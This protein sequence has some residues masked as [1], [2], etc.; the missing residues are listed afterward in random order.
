MYPPSTVAL[1]QPRLREIANRLSQMNGRGHELAERLNDLRGRVGMPM[2]TPT[3]PEPGKG[4]P[5]RA[6]EPDALTLL[7]MACDNYAAVL[8]R[9][10]AQADA[11][12]GLA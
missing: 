8:R 9:I 3:N 12:G 11:L 4:E 10:E 2:Q 6:G 1:A 5:L 7:E